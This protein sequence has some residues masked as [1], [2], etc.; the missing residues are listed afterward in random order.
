M[1]KKIIIKLPPIDLLK[2]TSE[3]RKARINNQGSSMT[4]KIV[5]SKRKLDKKK[6]RQLN[7][8]EINEYV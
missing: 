2:E 1:K 4:T 3:E 6:Q 5:P 8:K 7:K